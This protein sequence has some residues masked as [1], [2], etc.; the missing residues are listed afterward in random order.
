MRTDFRPPICTDVIVEQLR[1]A[2]LDWAISG[3]SKQEI[4]D[5]FA[6]LASEVLAI[7]RELDL[8]PREGA[9]AAVRAIMRR[10]LAPGA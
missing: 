3:H 4:G 7:S 5:A 6:R 10:A 2:A 9:L 1:G 8:G